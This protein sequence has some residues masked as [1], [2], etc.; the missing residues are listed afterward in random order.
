MYFFFLNGKHAL[1]KTKKKITDVDH[2]VEIS[3][4]QTG[5][6]AKELL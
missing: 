5:S 4:M 3:K 6:C 1:N 2:S